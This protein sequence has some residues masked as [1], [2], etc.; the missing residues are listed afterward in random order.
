MEE[1]WEDEG[2][3]GRD[4]MKGRRCGGE[5]EGWEDEGRRGTDGMKGRRS[6]EEG[7][8]GGGVGG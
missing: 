5:E 8:R 1:G 6:G 4:G 7:R 2:R 3:R